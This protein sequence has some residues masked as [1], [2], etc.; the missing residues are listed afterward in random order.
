MSID[1]ITQGKYETVR[2]L[3][4]G[5]TG[6]A[7]LAKP[8]G[9]DNAP[10]VVIK[11]PAGSL[12][13]RQGM[14]TEASVLEKLRDA[15]VLETTRLEDVGRIGERITYFATE[16][17]GT[18]YTEILK[19]RDGTRQLTAVEFLRVWHAVTRLISQA[20]QLGFLHNDFENKPEHVW[21]SRNPLTSGSDEP[22]VKI[23]DWGNAVWLKDNLSARSEVHD[24]RGSARLLLEAWFGVDY[25]DFTASVR[26]NRSADRPTKVVSLLSDAADGRYT[27][28]AQLLEKIGA[29][30]TDHETGILAKIAA[31]DVALVSDEFERLLADLRTDDPENPSLAALE[32]ER[33]AVRA[34]VTQWRALN[35]AY[36]GL[37]DG[38]S[39]APSDFDEVSTMYLDSRGRTIS[40]LRAKQA[41]AAALK[42][43][44]ATWVL[45]DVHHVTFPEIHYRIGM[46]AGTDS[47]FLGLNR[48]QREPIVKFLMAHSPEGLNEAL[49]LMLFGTRP[50]SELEI[51]SLAVSPYASPFNPG[52]DGTD[53]SLVRLLLL[54]GAKRSLLDD[55]LADL[56]TEVGQM[57]TS[58]EDADIDVV[59]A[60]RA[61]VAAEGPASSPFEAIKRWIESIKV[62]LE[63]IN[64]AARATND[65]RL[66][67]ASVDLVVAELSTT[68]ASVLEAWN[69]GNVVPTLGHLRELV[70]LDPGASRWVAECI[71]RCI[72]VAQARA[73]LREYSN[74]QFNSYDSLRATKTHSLLNPI[75]DSSWALSTIVVLDWL[76]EQMTRLAGAGSVEDKQA[77]D[78]RKRVLEWAFDARL[79][80]LESGKRFP[81]L[82]DGW[83]AAAEGLLDSIGVRTTSD[84]TSGD[85][86]LGR[87]GTLIGLI[88]DLRKAEDDTWN[89]VSVRDLEPLADLLDRGDR[90]A[91]DSDLSPFAR[92]AWMNARERGALVQDVFS[93]LATARD[94]WKWAAHPA[95]AKAVGDAA[96]SLDALAALTVPSGGS[97]RRADAGLGQRI[98][99]AKA[100]LDTYAAT[101]ATM[102]RHCETYGKRVE[103]GTTFMEAWSMVC[104]L[105]GSP[106]K[107]ALAG[108]HAV[109]ALL[110]QRTVPALAGE[111]DDLFSTQWQQF[112]IAPPPLTLS[113]VPD[114]LKTQATVLR[115]K[116][117]L[118]HY[119][120]GMTFLG[121]L[122]WVAATFWGAHLLVWAVSFTTGLLAERW[123]DQ[124]MV[125]AATRAMWQPL[126]A[127]LLLFVVTTLLAW[128]ARRSPSL[129][130][131]V[132]IP[133]MALLTWALIAIIGPMAPFNG[134]EA[135]PQPPCTANDAALAG[136]TTALRNGGK[137]VA[138]E[139]FNG[140]AATPP[141]FTSS[142][143]SYLVTTPGDPASLTRGLSG[144]PSGCAFQFAGPTPP[145]PLRAGQVVGLVPV[146]RT[147]TRTPTVE[148][149]PPTS[150]PTPVPVSAPPAPVTNGTA[151]AD[152]E[153]TATPLP[154][155]G[156]QPT[157]TAVTNRQSP[158]P[159]RSATPPSA[160]TA[161]SQPA[162]SQTATPGDGKR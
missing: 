93:N 94:A 74:D 35:R 62:F 41:R 99:D 24:I 64:P 125:L 79:R 91:A 128:L 119:R 156:N 51:A 86:I 59:D 154:T 120:Q 9:D 111:F 40:E 32:L 6:D 77:E 157:A 73:S 138:T 127:V 131:L 3:G 140:P 55:L 116:A 145:D 1:A 104:Q 44:G 36:S 130:G 43:S 4:G 158:L 52:E 70:L 137:G 34:T 143:V 162:P 101:M 50:A 124:R 37:I 105:A 13:A 81:E 12:L 42:Q 11:V 98:G 65:V 100:A 146:A 56:R 88:L 31:L 14:T 49:A 39:E 58:I 78:A 126:L 72:L 150:S 102:A 161:P 30:Q 54:G 75:R 20:H 160:T 92:R 60:R 83:K 121:A 67:H 133:G 159:T 110:D 129:T 112:P 68:F 33:P 76:V 122:P 139:T 144:T 109:D 5:I 15:N 103:Q 69:A 16:Y 142:P 45:D 115:E 136:I 71:H 53:A 23:L 57:D 28:A 25:R 22:L 90:R 107:T 118:V 61:S 87:E 48:K 149:Q 89:A 63:V 117:I 106:K 19:F 151:P 21:I 152:D 7:W 2:H 17:L 47:L 95:V 66:A 46:A 114:P 10:Q 148:A 135:Q 27:D 108:L 155:A 113:L 141:T 8:A 153:T 134:F 18:G 84:A 29:L 96:K 26:S 147:A 123:T 38:R 85:P 97:R 82:G 132:T 80:A